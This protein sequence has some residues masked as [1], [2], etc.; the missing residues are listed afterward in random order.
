M[1]HLCEHHKHMMKQ[2][3]DVIKKMDITLF[4]LQLQYPADLIV[5]AL[6]ALSAQY[7][8]SSNHEEDSKKRFLGMLE[9]S[10][11]DLKA[12]GYP[13]KVMDSAG[14]RIRRDVRDRPKSEF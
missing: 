1:T 5:A 13:E 7:I 14:V 9:S 3:N 6:A 8:L 4:H 10:M 12:V 11:L 2:L